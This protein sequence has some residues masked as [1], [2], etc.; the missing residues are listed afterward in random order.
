MSGI[1]TSSIGKKLIMSISGCFLVLFLIFHMAMNSVLIFSDEAYNAICAFLGS[2]WYAIAGTMVLA[3]G[4]GVHIL[5]AVI[6]TLQ[7]RRA[8]GNI[9]YA[10]TANEKGVEWSSKNM[11][12]LGLVVLIGLVIHLY[13]FWYNMMFVEIMGGHENQF[14][15]HPADGAALIRFTFSHIGYVVVYLVW[16]VAL[17]FHLT[18]GVWSMLQTV[19]F[20]NSVWLKRIKCVSYIVTTLIVLVFMAQV[21]IIH[22][23]GIM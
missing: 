16:M 18:H 19:G 8:R 14:G 1:F 10:V 12:V 11:F 3:L 20:S 22:L 7:N 5:Y 2:N 23:Q 6:L 17:W 15:F 4:V 21:V 9:R 13:N